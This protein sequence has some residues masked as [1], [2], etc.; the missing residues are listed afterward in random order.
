MRG[1][2]I[3][4]KVVGDPIIFTTGAFLQP[5]KI[6]DKWYW[7]A[8]G[9]EDDSYLDGETCD[10]LITADSQEELLRKDEEWEA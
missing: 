2:I 5:V 1:Y 7:M 4:R 9:F 10:P 6:N 8:V 3:E